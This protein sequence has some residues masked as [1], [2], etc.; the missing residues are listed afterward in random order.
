MDIPAL[1]LS[2]QTEAGLQVRQ[3]PASN[4]HLEPLAPWTLA[5][6]EEILGLA[7][8]LLGSSCKSGSGVAS[9]D[10]CGVCWTYALPTLSPLCS[11]DADS[12]DRMI[13]APSGLQVGLV[14]GRHQKE[15]G[16]WREGA[17]GGCSP[18]TPRLAMER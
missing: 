15:T 16:G 9:Q 14:H 10:G 1:V 7:P 17:Q 3:G 13:Q 2:L 11:P 8:R 18:L 6:L 5:A 12:V 4:C